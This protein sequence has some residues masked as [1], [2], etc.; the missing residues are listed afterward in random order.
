MRFCAALAVVL[1]SASSSVRQ[2]QAADC[3]GC[4][5]A[6]SKSHLGS[7]MSQAMLP[8]P[9]TAFWRNIPNAPLHE[10]GEGFSLQF[11]R[12]DD[13]IVVDASKGA[14][15]LT[16]AIE[17]I[18]GAGAQGQTPLVRTSTGELLESRV[19]YFTK[20]NRFG[21]T[22][23]QSGGASPSAIKALGFQHTDH[24]TKECIA[25]HATSVNKDFEPVVPGIQCL[26]C[27][28][29]ATE[30]SEN[31]V[32]RPVN[33]GRMKA[34]EQV[35]FCGTCHRSRPP[36]DDFQLENVRFQPLRLMKSRCF[37]TEQLSCTTC[38]AAHQDAK[39]SDAAFY[40][41]KC[42]SCHAAADAPKHPARD[43]RATGN[44]IG[45]HMPYLELHP[46][47]HFTDHFI[48]VVRNGDLPPDSLKVRD[49]GS[50]SE[51]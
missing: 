2:T 32:K 15:H 12:S 48:R 36:V 45:C 47:L 38:H 16:G 42:A 35:R 4:H 7:R 50:T 6:E 10:T 34:A 9:S 22:I 27:H 46:G 26:R 33:P 37:R 24:E 29:G 11:S 23:G 39:R 28:T 17:W 13:R 44:C 18:L 19:S 25:C 31:P 30:H 43:S 20:L 21:I 40:D 1:V 5:P 14:V 49:D 41:E 8:A 51:K 3:A